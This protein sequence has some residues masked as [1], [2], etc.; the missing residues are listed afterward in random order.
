[1][2][3]LI[4]GVWWS[5]EVGLFANA[6]VEWFVFSWSDRC[7]NNPDC[8]AMEN[9]YVLRFAMLTVVNSKITISWNVMACC[10]V[11]TFCGTCCL[12]F[13][14]WYL[15]TKLHGVILQNTVI[16]TQTAVFL[17]VMPYSAERAQSFRG[18]VEAL[19]YGFDSWWGDWVFQLT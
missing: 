14:P 2:C 10:L 4:C 18:L 3:T 11:P 5:S 6:P 16:F 19:C 15:I 1:M 12:N 8:W 17:I 9:C 13:D 7:R